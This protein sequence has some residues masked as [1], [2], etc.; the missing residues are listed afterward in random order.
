MPT[1]SLSL[2]QAPYSQVFSFSPGEKININVLFDEG[3]V[4][5]RY[6]LQILDHKKNTRLNRYGKGFANIIVN[7]WPIPTRLRDEH[8]GVWQVWIEDLKG[9]T[10]PYGHFF[11]VEKE[12]RRE[13][14]M[15][16]GISVLQLPQQLFL[17]QIMEGEP[18]GKPDLI[19]AR[20]TSKAPTG[21][22]IESAIPVTAIHGIGKTYADRL[23]QLKIISVSDLWNF[24]DRLTLAQTMRV[25]DRKLDSIMHNAN[26][27]LEQESGS[28]VYRQTKG[29][30]IEQMSPPKPGDA[31][32]MPVTKIKGIG[33]VTARK[34][35]IIGIVTIED[36]LNS[37]YAD[38]DSITTK[39]TFLK[40][41]NNAS[42]LETG[43]P[44]AKAQPLKP[45]K[46]RVTTD[47]EGGQLSNLRGIGQK[48]EHKLNLLGIYTVKDI[49]TYE[50]REELRKVLRMSQLR[51]QTFLESLKLE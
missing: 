38:M 32:S 29:V 3:Q 28:D 42:L 2:S 51:F 16:E 19:S 50:N 13:I 4:P 43:P 24:R 6:R 35:S 45:T 8:L 9:T 11:Y 15:I 49:T 22:V 25:S 36:F 30:K 44:S 26:L 17:D 20:M 31:L 12:G 7:E 48:T 47:L 1:I 21:G 40:W 27:I 41:M 33:Q 39:K 23:S 14:P 10:K 5:E 46:G 34:L 37:S 18:I